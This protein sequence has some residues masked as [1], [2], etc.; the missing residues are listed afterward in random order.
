MAKQIIEVECAC[1]GG[2]FQRLRH[3]IHCALGEQLIFF[4]RPHLKRYYANGKIKK[5]LSSSEIRNKEL[6]KPVEA[7]VVS[8]LEFS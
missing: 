8:G 7:N 6:N 3:S 4:N 1:C 5:I 2:K